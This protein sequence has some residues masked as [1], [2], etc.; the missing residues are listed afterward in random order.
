L[1]VPA[2]GAASAIERRFDVPAAGRLEVDSEGASVEIT[3]GG[4]G[5][6]RVSISRGTDDEAEFLEDYRVDIRQEGDL[7]RV[8]LE[9]RRPWRLFDFGSHSPEIEIELPRQFTADVVTSGGA[10]SIEDLDGA[11]KARTSGGSI[12]LAAIGGPVL[13]STSGGSIRLVSSAGDADLRT[14]GGSITIGEVEGTIEART[15]GGSISI[16]RASGPVTATTSGGSIEIEEVRGAI[17]A[18]TSGGSV[19]AYLSEPPAADSQLRTSGG[20]ITVYLDSAIGVDLDARASGRVTSD[21]EVAGGERDDDMLVGAINGGG[22][23]LLLR[24][25]GGGI[26]VLR[27]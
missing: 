4:A 6:A 24:T 18:S 8:E 20:G 5:G 2:A 26:R 1:A 14:S 27:R 23:A 13:A 3:T 16:E 11:V 19:R 15:S 7:L 9:R 25:S 22:P 10:V 17:V 21:F 12:R